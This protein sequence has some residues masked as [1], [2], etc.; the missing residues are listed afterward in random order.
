LVLKHF[1]APE[2]LRDDRRSAMSPSKSKKASGRKTSARAKAARPRSKAAAKSAASK[3]TAKKAAPRKREARKTTSKA[4]GKTGRKAAAK[5]VVAKKTVAKKVSAKPASA[6][7]NAGTR[8]IT[9]VN[10]TAGKAK[11]PA[12][13]HVEPAKKPARPVAARPAE[14]KPAA[15]PRKASADKDRSVTPTVAR[16]HFLEILKAKQE[17]VRQGPAYPPA[18]AFTGQRDAAAAAPSGDAPTPAS[19]PAEP[20]GTFDGPELAHGRGNQGMRP[21][22]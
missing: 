2:Q 15:Q 5:N 10:N 19:E 20:A 21:Q 17:R 16:R 14:R 13:A 3:K 1:S 22:K 7:K 11:R 6:A 18:N 4:P 9:E 12:A 8:K